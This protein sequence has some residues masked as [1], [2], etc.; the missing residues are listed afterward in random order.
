MEIITQL[1]SP[2][3]PAFTPKIGVKKVPVM[4]T[5]TEALQSLYVARAGTDEEKDALV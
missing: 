1:V 5:I 2:V 4:S 3:S